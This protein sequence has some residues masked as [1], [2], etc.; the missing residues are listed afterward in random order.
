M[1]AK[2]GTVFGEEMIGNA[3]EISM[4]CVEINGMM[5]GET[6]ISRFTYRNL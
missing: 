4:M 1:V 2:A 6:Q 3:D 5:C